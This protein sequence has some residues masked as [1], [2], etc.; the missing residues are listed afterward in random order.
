VKTKASVVIGG[1]LVALWALQALAQEARPWWP[2]AVEEALVR[3]DKNRPELEKALYGAQADQRQAMIFLIANMPDKDLRSLKPDFLLDNV[4]LTYKARKQVPWG[5]KI[6]DNIF[7]N[8]VLPYA[9]VDEER[10]AWRKELYE[11]CMPLVKD[12]KTPT[13]AVQILNVKVFEKLKVRYSTQRKKPHQSP[14]ESIEI[15]VASCTGLSILLSDAC[16]S[17]CIPARLVGTPLWTNKTG[18]HTWIEIWDNGWHFTGACEPDPKGLDRGW[19]VGNASQ[20]KKDVPQHAIYAASFQ[21]TKVTFPL[22]WAPNKKE[23]YAEN[24]TDRYAKETVAA[25]NQIRVL[26]RVWEAGR[27]KRVAVPLVVT[28]VKDTTKVFKGESRGESNDKNDI[29]GF[30]LHANHEYSLVIEKPVRLEK[31]IKTTAEKEQVIEIELPAAQNPTAVLTTAQVEQEALAFFSATAEQQAKWQFDARFDQLLAG[32]DAAVRAAVWKAYL[33]APIHAK[34]RKEFEEDLVRSRD[35][36]SAY[37]MHEVGKRP[38][39]GWPLFIAMHGGGGAPKQVNDSQ[40]KIMEKYYKDQASVTGYKYLALRAPNDTWNGFYDEYVPPL[41]MNLIK[42]FLIFGDVDP[43]K[44]FLMGYSHGGY[45]AFYIGP[46]IPDRFAAIHASA[47]APTD[48]TISPLS[49]RNTRFTFMVGENDTAYGR[50]ERCEKFDKEIQKLK[51]DEGGG[52]PVEFEFKKGFGHGGL[53][54]RDKIKEMYSFTRIVVPRHLTWELTD[55]VLTDHFWLSVA[56]PQKGQS[57]DVTIHNNDVH[58]TARKVDRFDLCLDSR[59]ITF[60]QPL[61]I[62]LGDSTKA[63]NVRPKLLTLCES[64]LERGDPQLA[65]TC[66][67]LVDA[68]KK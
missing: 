7:F 36:V 61:R 37:K 64:I 29:A 45:G 66:R 26:V 27:K 65:C 32:D 19:F 17:V 59:L 44:V 62:K 30:N 58:V 25:D 14:K 56:K 35:H 52:Y 3:A 1:L 31:Q 15:G 33:R 13:E 6:P 43:D 8:D 67:I 50:R 34:A 12:C 53:P 60:D 40:W 39:K 51:E 42:Q 38:D 28:D 41:I 18:N 11:L 21:K 55:A 4:E 24:V 10:D 47:A 49:L 54:D 5:A 2:A 63:L 48:G 22:V 9:N 23:V 68:S 16:R 46:K 20:A 57:I